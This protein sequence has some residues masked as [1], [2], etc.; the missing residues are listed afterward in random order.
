MRDIFLTVFSSGI[1]A[2]M[3]DRLWAAF[4]GKK[5]QKIS[6]VAYVIDWLLGALAFQTN[7]WLRG[8]HYTSSPLTE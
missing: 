4:E 6:Q 8:Q 1:D 7:K 2:A 5:A 3:Q